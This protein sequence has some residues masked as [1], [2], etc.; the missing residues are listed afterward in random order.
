MFKADIQCMPDGHVRPFWKKQ[1][2]AELGYTKWLPHILQYILLLAISVCQYL[3]DSPN[4]DKELIS[5]VPLAESL[6]N[7]FLSSAS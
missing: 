7:H 5:R 1:S 3:L 2:Q 4:G 6:S